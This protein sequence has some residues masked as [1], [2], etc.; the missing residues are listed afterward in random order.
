MVHFISQEMVLFTTQCFGINFKRKTCERSEA[1]F[2]SV[3]ANKSHVHIRGVCVCG[4]TQAEANIGPGF[5]VAL[6]HKFTNPQPSSHWLLSSIH[7][8]CR[9]RRSQSPPE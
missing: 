4:V 3:F 2:E 8:Y 7:R 5:L 1:F 6:L 9:L